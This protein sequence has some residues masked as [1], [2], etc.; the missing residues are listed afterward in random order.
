MEL[1]VYLSREDCLNVAFAFGADCVILDTQRTRPVTE[2]DFDLKSIEAARGRARKLDKKVSVWFPAVPKQRQLPDIASV[3]DSIA[4]IGIECVIIKDPSLIAL[5]GG[6]GI[7]QFVLDPETPVAN[8]ASASFWQAQG[9]T[10]WFP[11]FD[12]SAQDLKELLGISNGRGFSYIGFCAIGAGGVPIFS[13]A[14][15]SGAWL[16]FSAL[17]HLNSL[18][19]FGVRKLVSFPPM[20]SRTS[21][22]L[23]TRA[24]KR[25]IDEAVNGKL[26]A[27]KTRKSQRELQ[28]VCRRPISRGFLPGFFHN[29]RHAKIAGT[30]LGGEVCGIVRE[31]FADQG[32]ARVMLQTSVAAGDDLEVITPDGD[33]RFTLGAA[34]LM[35]EDGHALERAMAEETREISLFLPKKA[36]PYS[37][38]IKL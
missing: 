14:G 28:S 31:F 32:R 15:K 20:Q 16:G 1:S 25:C 22:A 26:T 11:P 10:S 6:R 12:C 2:S 9:L 33:Y 36:A 7:K 5:L 34:S 18:Y 13:G 38:V 37:L 24:I 17:D 30:R 29:P 27:A 8:M 19:E 35:D 23:S 21:I 4:R 3:A